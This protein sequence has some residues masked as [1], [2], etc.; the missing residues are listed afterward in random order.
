M[1]EGVRGPA[2]G[3]HNHRRVG[4]PQFEVAILTADLRRASQPGRVQPLDV[5]RRGKV[6][7]ERQLRVHAESGE[8]QVVRLR[9]HEGGHDQLALPADRRVY[10][11]GVVGIGRVGRGV[12]NAGVDD[13]RRGRP[14][15]SRRIDSASRPTG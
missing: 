12:Q 6:V 13:Q 4:E 2:I 11:R 10:G 9:R 3:E 7:D 15:S 8:D 14:S 5:I 1:Y